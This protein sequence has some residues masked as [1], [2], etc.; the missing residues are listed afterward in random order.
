MGRLIGTTT[1]YSFLASRNFTS[2]YT[3]DAASNRTGFTDPE[4][5][6]T[7]YAYD[8]L[9]RLTSLAPPSASASTAWPA[10]YC[11]DESPEGMPPKQS[12][13]D[14]DFTN[15]KKQFID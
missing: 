6:S 10:A 12:K 8:T 1:S 9:N 3:Y 7:T 15:T 5:G 2:A 13:P 4:S 11:G 14:W